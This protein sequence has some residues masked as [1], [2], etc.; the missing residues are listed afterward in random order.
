MHNNIQRII[1]YGLIL[2]SIFL[3]NALNAQSVDIDKLS[4]EVGIKPDMYSIK[5]DSWSYTNPIA[6]LLLAHACLAYNFNH[7]SI[8]L[9][10]S[11][12]SD[13]DILLWLNWTRAYRQK[14][15]DNVE[16]YILSADAYFRRGILDSALI[17]LNRSLDLKKDNAMAY[18]WHGTVK[19]SQQKLAESIADF[20]NCID[21]DSNFA[22]CHYNL[23]LV[24]QKL[25]KY[26]KAIS[27][28]KRDRLI[29]RFD[30]KAYLNGALCH[31]LQNEYEAALVLLDSLIDIDSTYYVAYLSKGNIFREINMPKKA[32]AEYN[33]LIEYAPPENE[34][35]IQQYRDT[36]KVLESNLK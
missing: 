16:A 19:Y 11:I 9:F 35:L 12:T 20:K 36:I 25:H 31:V 33:K 2:V 7:I 23:G 4:N 28:Y 34:I 27:Y 26:Q 13:D 17:M 15:T 32:I 6:R 3:Y 8:D 22:E 29:N 21:I 18:L 10:Y 24:Y 30:K 1:Y 5:P 14:N